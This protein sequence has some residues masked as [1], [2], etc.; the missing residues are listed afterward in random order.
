M[1]TF[2]VQALVDDLYREGGERFPTYDTMV[3]NHFCSRMLRTF[4][5][6]N[7]D[8]RGIV[9]FDYAR[10]KYG[11]LSP[12]EIE[13]VEAK[14]AENGYCSHGLTWLTCPLG[15]FEGEEELEYEDP[16]FED[17]DYEEHDFEELTSEEIAQ[18][19]A[20]YYAEEAE[21]YA[22]NKT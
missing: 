21:L 18:A 13:K 12:S 14:D 22:G 5:D 7:Q 6:E 16:E 9:A 3:F 1:D 17:P 4:G 10:S 20:E 2:E 19:E 15:C 11:Y 8:S